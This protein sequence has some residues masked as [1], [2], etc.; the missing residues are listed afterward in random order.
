ML[1][2][3]KSIMKPTESAEYFTHDEVKILGKVSNTESEP[4]SSRN[5][6]HFRMPRA[7][8]VARNGAHESG[9]LTRLALPSDTFTSRLSIQPLLTI[10]KLRAVVRLKMHILQGDRPH[11]ENTIIEVDP[12]PFTFALLGVSRHSHNKSM[13]Q[14]RHFV[15]LTTRLPTTHR[16]SPVRHTQQI[17]SAL[18]QHPRPVIMVPPTTTCINRWLRKQNPNNFVRIKCSRIYWRLAKTSAMSRAT[19]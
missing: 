6:F 10:T 5:A 1:R 18:I 4:G 2:T 12:F 7:L 17:R 16:Q 19:K 15:I 8:K 11:G 9:T 14:H 3:L 13:R